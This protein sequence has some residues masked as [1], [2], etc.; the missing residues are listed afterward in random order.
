[1]IKKIAAWLGYRLLRYG[2]PEV[3]CEWHDSCDCSPG[4]KEQKCED[5]FWYKFVDSGYGFCKAL[6]EPIIVG[7]CRDTCSLFK[8]KVEVNIEYQEVKS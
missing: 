1:M 7:W 3:D 8:K 6:P 2:Q 5:C 4:K